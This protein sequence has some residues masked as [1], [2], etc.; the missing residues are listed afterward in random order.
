[1]HFS[2]ITTEDGSHSLHS[3]EMNEG[4]HSVHGALSESM[5]VFVD[6]G[7]NKVC[8]AKESINILEIGFGTGLNAFLTRY[9]CEARGIRATYWGVE[10]FPVAEDIYSQLNYHTILNKTNQQYFLDL[11]TAEWNKPVQVSEKFLLTK[12]A[13]PI[14]EVTLPE[15]FFD[16]V[17]FDAFAPQYQPEMWTVEV[18]E[19]IYNAMSQ[20]ATLTTYCCKG[21]VKRTLKSVG[22]RIEKIPG[23]KGKRE[24]LRANK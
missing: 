12:Y 9:H 7:L 18:F 10:A 21:D 15:G 17:Y 24:M 22:F 3:K 23:P 1:M 8:E 4:Y 16:L 20:G 14:Q 19:K 5:H 6:A 13:L 11:H 2:L